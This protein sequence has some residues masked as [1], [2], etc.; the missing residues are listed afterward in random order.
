MLQWVYNVFYCEYLR[1]FG[2]EGSWDRECPG[3]KFCETAR[4]VLI[5]AWWLLVLQTL[6]LAGSVAFGSVYLAVAWYFNRGLYINVLSVIGIRR[7]NNSGR[8]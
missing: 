4:G 8:E 3:C 1:I 7:R 2:A 5:I 6:G